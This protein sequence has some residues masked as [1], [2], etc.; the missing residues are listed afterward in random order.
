MS[1][2]HTIVVRFPEG[3][4]PRYSASTQFQGGDVVAVS[5]AGNRMDIA[6]EL[7]EALAAFERVAE[8]WLPPNDLAPENHGEGEAL[9]GLHRKMLDALT[10]AR[11][12]S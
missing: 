10:K 8:L 5:F 4:V 9:C 3:I 12:S 11:G 2:T 7:Y 1:Q 6:D